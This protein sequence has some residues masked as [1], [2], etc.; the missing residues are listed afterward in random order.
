MKL[1]KGLL[2]GFASLFGL[3]GQA[4]AQSGDHVTYVVR[5][6][7]TLHD[8]ARE[9]FISQRVVPALMRLNRIRDPRKLQIGSSLRIPRPLLRYE[10]EPLRILAFSGPVTLSRSGTELAPRVGEQ[11]L[12]GSLVRTGAKGFISFG[13]T[14]NSRLSLPSNSLVQI[15]EAKRYLINNAID[16]DV[17]VL[18]GRT[19]TRAPQLKADERYRIGTPLAVT[20]VRGTEFRVAYDDRTEL[21]LTEVTE[22][23]VVVSAGTAD[24]V[25]AAGAGIA[26]VAGTLGRAEPLLPAPEVVEAGRIQTED[27]VVFALVGI[28]NARAY[29][30]QIARDAGFIELVAE[31]IGSDTQARFESI[32][33]GRFFVRSRAVADSGLEGFAGTY[34]FRRK[35]LGVSANVEPSPFEDLFKFAWLPEGEGESFAAFQLWNADDADSM[36][37]D[38]VGLQN[39]GFYVGPLAPG[40]YLWRVATFQIDEGDVIKVWSPAQEF[41]V[42]E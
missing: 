31:E 36:I 7:D 14:G 1:A 17:R 6:G 8:L 5:Q 10:P 27:N 23:T 20:A 12:E 29:R 13:G 16:F 25:A 4:L 33:D 22:G 35:R 11:V 21:S 32:E 37:V 38:E 2:V 40:K 41:T 18:E 39:K 30:T 42:S 9:Y 34:A 24:A 19:E 26:S 3:Q 28:E 15:R